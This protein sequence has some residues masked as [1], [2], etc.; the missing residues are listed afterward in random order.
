MIQYMSMAIDLQGRSL[1]PAKMASKSNLM[2]SVDVYVC[3]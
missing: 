3:R 2:D 1:T